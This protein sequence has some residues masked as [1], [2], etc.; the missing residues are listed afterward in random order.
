MPGSETSKHP[1]SLWYQWEHNPEKVTRDVVKAIR[2]IRPHVVITFN[3]YGGYGHPDH[4]AIQRATVKAFECANDASYETDGLAPYKSQKLYYNSFP[5]IMSR[6]RI[7]NTRLRRQNPRALGVNKDIDIVKVFE[8]IEPVHTR[9]PIAGYFDIWAKASQCHV[10]QGGGRI[11]N[12][13]KWLRRMLYG[14]HGFTRVYPKPTRDIVDENTVFAG[15][16][17]D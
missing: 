1:D 3:K 6:M 9:I 11:S 10:S 13:P 17:I 16:T 5:K 7:W 15:V 8:N 14:T 2:E 12:T 4:I